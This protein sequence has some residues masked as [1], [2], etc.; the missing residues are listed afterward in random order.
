M[1]FAS[2]MLLVAALA[3]SA[4]AT[5][6]PD[7]APWSSFLAH[8]L[9][10]S[11]PDGIVRVRYAQ[12]TPAD[13]KALAAFVKG[14]QAQKPSR[15][16]ADA[17]RAFWINLYNAK[18]IAIVL[19]HYPLDSIRAIQIPDSPKPG[20]WDAK[21][22][23][24]EDRDLSLNDIENNILRA[25]WK[26]PRIHFALNCASLGCPDLSS[27]AFTAANLNAMLDAGEKNFLASPRAAGFAG[28][29]LKLSSLFDWY[30]SD[31][32]LTERVVLTW[33]ERHAPPATATRIK[34]HHG[35]VVYVYD[36]KLNASGR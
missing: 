5:E 2:M 11:V 32:G 6:V 33:L 34:S 31:F 14:L 20:P 22:L 3:V 7:Y 8:Y 30:K 25:Q 12:V 17:Q 24:V 10:K 28:D 13:K 18:T 27:E 16:P 29:T 4:P 1:S 15:L 9:D 21:L 36:W 35:K 23:H 19:D 26:D